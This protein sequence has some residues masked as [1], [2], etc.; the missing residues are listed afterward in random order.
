METQ[1]MYLLYQKIAEQIIEIIPDGIKLLY[2]QRFQTTL[3]KYTFSLVQKIV[4]S[5]F[6]RMTFRDIIK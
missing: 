2:T 1:K 4:K 3:E 5:S 6:I